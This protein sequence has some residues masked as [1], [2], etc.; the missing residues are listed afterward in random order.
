MSRFAATTLRCAL[1]HFETAWLFTRSDFKTIIFPVMIF[2]TV[3]SPRHNPLSLSY[4]LCWLWFHLFQFNVSNQS[5]SA[6]EDVLNKPWR[7][8]ASGRISVKDSRTLRWGLMFFCLGLSSLFS[9]NVV[10]TSG[11]STV[12]L[13]MYDDFHLSYHP[14][15]KNLCNAGGYVTYELGCLL[16]LSRESSLDGTSIKALSCSALVIILTVHAQD[17]AD[18]NGDCRAG[19][20]T[21]PI[22]TPEGSRIYMLC[23]LPLFSFALASFWSFGPLSTVLFVSMGSWVGIRYFLFRDEICDQSTYRLYNI[24]LVGVHLLPANV[25]FRALVW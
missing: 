6:H 25:R 2:A 4:A 23:A 19:R 11:V 21:L 16:I 12:L 20:R 1:Y 22:I 7:P 13:V 9:L 10:I 8:V 5:Y 17:F 3:V 14:I 18:V 24:W 15:F